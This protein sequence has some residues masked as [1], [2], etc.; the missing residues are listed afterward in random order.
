M[1]ASGMNLTGPAFERVLV[2][3][4]I[5]FLI[6]LE[7]ERAETRKARRVFAGVRTF[8]LIALAGA[9]PMLVIRITGPALL[10][11]SFFAVASVTLVSYLRA[12]AAGSVGA[13]T[14]IAALTTFLL[15]ALAGAGEDTCTGRIG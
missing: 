13:T 11:A 1:D 10:I 8:P 6:G 4:L 9:V 15:G 14:E 7:R 12:S 2:A 5:G 3:A